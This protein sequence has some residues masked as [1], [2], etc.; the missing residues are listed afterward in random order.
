MC[1]WFL[2][3]ARETAQNKGLILNSRT[4][5]NHVEY[6]VTQGVHSYKAHRY[7][8]TEMSMFVIFNGTESCNH[9]VLLRDI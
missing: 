1:V 8:E 4:R 6:E 5:N 3:N 9:I 2:R 7:G